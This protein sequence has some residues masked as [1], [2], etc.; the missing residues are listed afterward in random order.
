MRDWSTCWISKRLTQ[1][2]TI[3]TTHDLDRAYCHNRSLQDVAPLDSGDGIGGDMKYL[4]ARE[5]TF[6]F[7]DA[8]GYQQGASRELFSR[9]YSRSDDVDRLHGSSC[10]FII[11]DKGSGKTALAT[12]FINGL[13]SKATALSL[14]VTKEAF[15]KFLDFRAR[16]NVPATDYG[17]I[18]KAIILL[19]LFRWR[20]QHSVSADQALDQSCIRLNEIIDRLTYGVFDL[21]VESAFD[22]ICE[23]RA[24]FFQELNSSILSPAVAPR[25]SVYL[26]VVRT[27]LLEAL[28]KFP[29]V[30][31]S[32]YCFIDGLDVRPTNIASEPAITHDEHTRNVTGLVSATWTLNTEDLKPHFGTSVRAIA[33]IRPDIF[34]RMEFQNINNIFRENAVLT[35]HDVNFRSY[36]SSSIFTFADHLL[37][38]QP[39]FFDKEQDYK[40]GLTWDKYLPDKMAHG[41]TFDSDPSQATRRQTI[42]SRP[43]SD[44]HLIDHGTSFI[45]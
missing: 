13:H 38:C 19:V 22:L 14:F 43:F 25:F 28:T 44:S 45:S 27:R 9:L 32:Y 12:Y 11:G 3:L 5:L 26:R 1:P 31:T 16:E 17:D 6:G 34:E 10:Y 8:K 24:E 4:P 23:Q 20:S 41:G 37:Y 42:R 30:D 21:S 15:N 29:A 7:A 18:W 33:L 40:A 36:R 35:D 39:E 2:L